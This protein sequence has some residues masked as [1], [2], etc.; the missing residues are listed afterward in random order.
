[1]YMQNPI[2]QESAIFT[3]IREICHIGLYHDWKYIPGSK[4]PWI[5]VD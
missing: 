1:M 4:G 3:G 2:F 5:D